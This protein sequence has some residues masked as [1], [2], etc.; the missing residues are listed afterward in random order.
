MTVLPAFFTDQPAWLDKVGRIYALLER[1][2]ISEERVADPVRL[3]RSNRISSV[4]SSIAIEGNRL[5]LEQV[6]AVADGLP[7]YAPTRDVLEGENALAAYD[8][9][10]SFDPCS[11][12]DFLRAHGILTRGLMTESGAF[13]TVEVAVVNADDEVLHTGSRPGKVPRLVAE[14]FEWAGTAEQH[15]LVVSSA[16]H[17]LI[18]HI[19]PFRDGNGRI[20]RLWQTLMLSRWN[21]LFE[22]MPTETLVRRNQA[23]Y[24][25][26]L[27]DSHEP[28]VDAAPFVTFMLDMI[29][30]SLEQYIT[31]AEQSGDGANDG[32]RDGANL[33][34]DATDQAVL[35]ALSQ[36]RTLTAADLAATV[37]KSQRTVERHLAKL[38]QAGLLSRHGSDKTGVWIVNKAP[39]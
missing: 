26:A 39:G 9:L 2:K 4:H 34:L 25:Q 8:V 19:H 33:R 31:T 29:E 28:E 14:L 17:Y 11:V 7:V 27:Q 23:G 20:G 13:R 37:G 15:P 22:W 21:P 3:R 30:S 12:D 36:D 38:A 16:T 6:N 10:G 24:Y 32:A 1:V 5:T 35:A 18:E